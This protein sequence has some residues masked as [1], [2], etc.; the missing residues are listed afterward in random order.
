MLK[1]KITVWDGGNDKECRD[2]DRVG[3]T[4]FSVRVPVHST[5]RDPTVCVGVLDCVAR[6]DTV[7]VL[8]SASLVRDTRIV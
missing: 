8:V 6:V 2:G 3:E 5:D 7:A 1:L 4:R